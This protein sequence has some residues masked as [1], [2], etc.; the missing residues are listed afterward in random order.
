MSEYDLEVSMP[1]ATDDPEIAVPLS[2]LRELEAAAI[3]A[4]SA[5]KSLRD[6]FAMAALQ[7]LV[8]RDVT[9][10]WSALDIAQAAYHHADS[11]LEAREQ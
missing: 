1:T 2:R 10:N 7:A 9:M 11:M 8:G 4:T 3:A 6:E 5:C